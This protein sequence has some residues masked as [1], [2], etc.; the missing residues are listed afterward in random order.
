MDSP[1]I[2]VPFHRA[3][4]RPNLVM[5]GDRRG[6]IFCLFMVAV[7]IIPSIN[8]FSITVGVLF[9]MFSIF[10]LREMAKRDPLMREVLTRQLRYNDYYPARSRQS[11][12][13]NSARVY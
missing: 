11:R 4:H 5:G 9:G 3:L 13:S 10:G 6:M 1:L 12:L 7:M 8:L 2:E